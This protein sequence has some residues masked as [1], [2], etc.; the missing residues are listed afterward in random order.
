MRPPIAMFIAAFMLAGCCVGG[1]PPVWSANAPPPFDA[2]HAGMKLAVGMPTDVAI[3]IIG[4]APVSAE[5]K[6][7]G[8]LAGYEWP[9]QVLKFGCC[10]GNQLLVYVAPTP[11]GRGAVNSWGLAKS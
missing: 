9:C 7:C 1:Y 6:S 10:E 4:S 3:L 2:F 11:D 8:I 5:V